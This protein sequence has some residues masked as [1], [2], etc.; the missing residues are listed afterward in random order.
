MVL[1]YTWGTLKKQHVFLKQPNDIHPTLKFKY[2]I[3]DTHGTF[4]DTIVFKGKRFQKENILDFKPSVKPSEKFQ[5]IH[6]QSS[7]PKPVFNGLIKGE[8]IRLVRTA[9]NKED[10]LNRTKLFKEKLLLQGYSANEFDTAFKSVDMETG[11]H[12]S[13]KRTGNIAAKH[14]LLSLR[15]ITHISVASRR[16]YHATGK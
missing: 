6:R 14:H 1:P 4:L 7:H 12:T 8:L 15:H 3:S 13:K 2:D 10:Y 16:L 5:Y 9:T 11:I